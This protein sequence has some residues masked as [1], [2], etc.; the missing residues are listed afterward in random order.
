MDVC[1]CSQ[2]DNLRL[3]CPRSENTGPVACKRARLCSHRERWSGR[4]SHERYHR[5]E[6]CE[7][8]V[9]RSAEPF[10]LD[11]LWP[12]TERLER[13][14]HSLFS[15]RDVVWCLYRVVGIVRYLP[16]T[17]QREA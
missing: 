9:A 14:G 15:F 5:P 16:S 8:Y 3:C 13:Y 11:E 17:I 2:A 10:R 6:M 12:F 7:H 4:R 1:A